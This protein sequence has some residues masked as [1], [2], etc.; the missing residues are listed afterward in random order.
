MNNDYEGSEEYKKML[1][2]TKKQKKLYQLINGY[3]INKNTI[4]LI[5][6]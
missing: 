5:V 4:K 6:H 1:E 2:I 3:G